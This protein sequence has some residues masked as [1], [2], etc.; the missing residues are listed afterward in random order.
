M[1][2]LSE[3]RT[4]PAASGIRETVQRYFDGLYHG[5]G[6]DIAAAFH[7][8]AM[9]AGI[10]SASGEFSEMSRD[11]F[12]RFVNERPAPADTGEPYEMDILSVEITGE[13]A[14]VKVVDRCH[15]KRFTDHLL[16]IK[17][18]GSWRIYGKLWHA[19]PV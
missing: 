18:G 1:A 7:P 14:S 9:I 8:S 19:D 11:D 10:M 6:S 15:G 2:A 17:T 12:I 3:E 5:R 16:L 13:I 4:A